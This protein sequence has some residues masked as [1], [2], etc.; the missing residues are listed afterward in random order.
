MILFAKKPDTTL[1][2]VGFMILAMLIFV[3][4]NV[5]LKLCQQPYPI[6]QIVFFR[7]FF[8]MT[9]CLL[10]IHKQRSWTDLRPKALPWHIVRGLGGVISLSCLFSSIQLLPFA[11]ATVLMFTATLFMTGL[12]STLLGES[13]GY[14]RTLAVL[15]GF[16]GI[17]AIA[18]PGA[19]HEGA[20]LG[21][22]CGITS[23]ILEAVI[24]LHNR[25]LTRIEAN[26][27]IVFYYALT[28]SCTCAM[29]LPFVW[30]TPTLQ[31]WGILILLGL[32]G[33]LGQYYQTMAYR[34]APAMV[35]APMLYS[36]MIWSVLYGILLFNETPTIGFLVGSILIVGSGLY[37][38]LA[39][40]SK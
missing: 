33:G 25:I 27:T 15:I 9:P 1:I 36:A 8:A 5:L 40:K 31:D 7:F 2:G 17:I 3:S 37:V 22:V 11:D 38:L 13:I 39:K 34:Y 32:G 24:L 4:V 16:L 12:A 21:I 18:Q 23:A 10:M 6:T 30:V 26:T 20:L 29:T 35:L 14:K 28:A 19:L